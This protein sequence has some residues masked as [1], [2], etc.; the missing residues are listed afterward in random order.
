MYGDLLRSVH[1]CVF[2]GVPHRGAE[3]AYWS[4]F[5]ANVIKVA[6]FGHVNANYV[7]ALQQNSRAFADISRQ[8]VERGASLKIRTFYETKMLD[9]QLV[10]RCDACVW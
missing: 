10:C 2:F 8:F 7:A 3:A 6:L 1:G 4:S 9:N 5:G